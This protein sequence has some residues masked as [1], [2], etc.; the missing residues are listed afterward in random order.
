MP[1]R[2]TY[3]GA[4]PPVYG[5]AGR[6]GGVKYLVLTGIGTLVALSQIVHMPHLTQHCDAVRRQCDLSERACAR[7]QMR[8]PYTTIDVAHG[9]GGGCPGGAGS[10][11]G[12]TW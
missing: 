5:L 8:V 10:S 2:A 1:G 3:A 11:V 9:G 7:E 6:G 4:A 12:D